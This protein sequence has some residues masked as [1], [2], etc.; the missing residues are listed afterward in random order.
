M[1]LAYIADIRTQFGC[2]GLFKAVSQ[3]SSHLSYGYFIEKSLHVQDALRARLLYDASAR[4]RTHEKTDIFDQ[5]L[6]SG[7]RGMIFGYEK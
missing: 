4:R 3:S 1:G 5:L 6:R 7:I 2:P